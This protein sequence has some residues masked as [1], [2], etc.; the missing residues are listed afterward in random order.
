MKTNKPLPACSLQLR[1]KFQ[2]LLHPE[3]LVSEHLYVDGRACITSRKQVMP[4]S[5]HQ[6]S[7]SQYVDWSKDLTELF[8]GCGL[9]K[10]HEKAP[11]SM[12]QYLL[13]QAPPDDLDLLCARLALESQ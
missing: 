6:T 10:L 4:K 5:I 1:G 9:K 12:F 7:V 13:H 8:S 2:I 3:N 11:R